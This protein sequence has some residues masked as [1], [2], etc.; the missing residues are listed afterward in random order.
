MEIGKDYIIHDH[1]G[2]ETSPI[3]ILLTPFVGVKF[4]FTTVRFRV[5]EPEDANGE[6]YAKVQFDYNLIDTK[7]HSE[8]SLRTNKSFQ[9]LAGLILNSIL[10]DAVDKGEFDEPETKSDE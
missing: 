7:E 3:E 8:V 2:E 6:E 5:V 9:E 1:K 4:N 10:L